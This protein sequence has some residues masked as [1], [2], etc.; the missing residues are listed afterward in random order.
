M[1]FDLSYAAFVERVGETFL[2]SREGMEPV[3]LEL[4]EVDDLRDPKR[5]LPSHV[6]QDP[7][8]LKLRGPI[9]PLLPQS[10]YTFSNDAIGDVQLFL[11][12]MGPEDGSHWYNVVVN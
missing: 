12:P 7:F 3:Q 4:V 8:Q 9:E 1:N 10:T 5:S 6:R 2:V 11:V